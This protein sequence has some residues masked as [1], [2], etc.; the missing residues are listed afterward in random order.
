MTPF[1]CKQVKSTVVLGFKTFARIFFTVTVEK[2]GSK[3]AIPDCLKLHTLAI[4]GVNY[5]RAPHFSR[6]L[7]ESLA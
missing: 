4:V 3:S 1:R 6:S 2:G 5:C 7:R